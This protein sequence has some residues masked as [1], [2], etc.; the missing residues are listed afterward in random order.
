MMKSGNYNRIKEV[1]EEQG[2]TQTWLA[3]KLNITFRQVNSY[4]SNASQPSIPVLY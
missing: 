2:R 4:C 1:L 3:K